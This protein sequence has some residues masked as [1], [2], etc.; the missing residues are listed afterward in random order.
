MIVVTVSNGTVNFIDSFA[1]LAIPFSIF[2]FVCVCVFSIDCG[3]SRF[4][5][6]TGCKQMRVIDERTGQDRTGQ[7]RDV[8]SRCDFRKRFFISIAR[9]R[10]PSVVNSRVFKDSIAP[11][12]GNTVSRRGKTLGKTMIPFRTGESVILV[13]VTIFSKLLTSLNRVSRSQT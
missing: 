9:T 3:C 2:R 5:A 13:D 1:Y 8:I 7:K 12:M 11:A 4:D 10:I 6:M